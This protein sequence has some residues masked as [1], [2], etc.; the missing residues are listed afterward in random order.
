MKGDGNERPD[1]NLVQPALKEKY[2]M[3]NDTA[4]ETLE[5]RLKHIKGSIHEVKSD[6]QSLVNQLVSQGIHLRECEKIAQDLNKSII[7]LKIR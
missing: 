4:I 5:A 7:D 2:Q 6:M 1:N 3:K